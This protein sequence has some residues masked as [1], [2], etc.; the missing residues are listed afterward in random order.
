MVGAKEIKLFEFWLKV[1]SGCVFMWWSVFWTLSFILSLY[2]KSHTYQR[3]DSLKCIS[4]LK[5]CSAVDNDQKVDHYISV[6]QM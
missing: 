4:K 6:S 1:Y 2:F 5:K 3:Q